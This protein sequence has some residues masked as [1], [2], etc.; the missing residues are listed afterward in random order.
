MWIM[1]AGPISAPTEDKRKLNLERLHRACLD[2]WQL[3]H[4]PILAHDVAEPVQSC[5]PPGEGHEAY[6]QICVAL[7]ERCDGVLMVGHSQGADLEMLVF[8]EAGKPVWESLDEVP[9]G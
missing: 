7:A 4:V 8:M 1:V 5:L 9:R 2:V 6:Q 3:G